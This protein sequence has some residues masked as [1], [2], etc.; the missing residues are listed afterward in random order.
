MGSPKSEEP[1]PATVNRAV[2][3]FEPVNMLAGMTIC[4]LAGYLAWLGA[5]GVDLPV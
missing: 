2:R 5:S 3:D 4:Q 1:V